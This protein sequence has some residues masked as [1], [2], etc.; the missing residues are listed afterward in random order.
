MF[1]STKNTLT[2]LACAFALTATA[3]A[4]NKVAPA[5]AAPA[6]A[7]PAKAAPA[8]KAAA[9]AKA[10]PKKAA[11]VKTAPK[12]AAPAKTAPKQASPAKKAAVKVAPAKKAPTKTAAT[13]KATTGFTTAKT[14]QPKKMKLSF[15]DGSKFGYA[16][17]Y[18][19]VK[20]MKMSL[21]RGGIKVNDKALL[22]GVRDALK[23]KGRLSQGEIRMT[24][25]LLQQQFQR[26]MMAKRKNSG[27][28]NRIMG[29]RFLAANAKRK[30][31]VVLKSGLQYMIIKQG[32]GKTPKA[33]DTVVTHYRGTLINGT[34]F[35]SSYKRKVPATFPV[36][37]VIK[38]WTEALQL[39]KEGA[40]WKLFIPSHLAYGA[41]GAGRRIGPHSTLIFDI[42]LI[43]VKAKK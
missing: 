22:A 25:M 36:N 39:M 5:K 21:A 29:L 18:N 19:F 33:T 7:A 2:V 6:K 15:A 14:T 1:K 24:M 42:E 20:R 40:K 30:G 34:E 41:R 10:A 26:N 38:G 11:P 17:G 16:L 28:K 12:K 9:P 35:D 37:G 31:V 32:S 3:Q 13:T 43:K 27:S 23:G 4:N 8:K